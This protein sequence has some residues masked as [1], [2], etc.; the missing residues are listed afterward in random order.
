MFALKSDGNLYAWGNN[1]L[2]FLGGG[3]WSNQSTPVN[4]FYG[5]WNTPLYKQISASFGCQTIQDGDYTYY[6]P[7]G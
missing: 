1:N 7:G 6:N 4:I 5:S 3:S 2:G